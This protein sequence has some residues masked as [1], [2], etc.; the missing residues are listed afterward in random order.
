MSES[1]DLRAAVIAL[2]REV[3][4]STSDFGASPRSPDERGRLG[5]AWLR[6]RICP[7]S[8]ELLRRARASETELATA[9]IDL[10]AFAFGNQLPGLP[11]LAKALVQIGLERFCADPNGTL[12]SLA[13]VSDADQPE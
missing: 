2:G 4:R 7:H 1:E 5:I 10:I 8:E 6:D 3:E 13:G 9:I 11:T 12:A